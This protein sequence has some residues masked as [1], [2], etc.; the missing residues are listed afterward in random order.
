MHLQK[1]QDC[2]QQML[3]LGQ[4]QNMPQQAQFDQARMLVGLGGGLNPMSFMAGGGNMPALAQSQQQSTNINGASSTQGSIGGNSGGN[5]N[6]SSTVP[7][8]Q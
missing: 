6:S 3:R 1:Q 5:G 4:P 8:Q 2:N 7:P